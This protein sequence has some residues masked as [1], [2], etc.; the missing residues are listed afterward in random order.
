[1]KLKILYFS[2]LGLIGMFCVYSAVNAQS[3]VIS[4]GY[5]VQA[6]IPIP[7]A[8]AT[9]APITTH[10]L[11]LV[12]L[13]MPSSLTST[14][15]TFAVSST[16]NGTY[17][18]LYNSSGQVSYTVAASRYISINPSDFNGVY[19]FEVIMG[20]TE[21]AARTLTASMKGI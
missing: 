4:Q 20:S 17:V 19:Y 9:S 5:L 18:P 8:S 6:P 12:G 14:S 11:N 21:A 16:L 13:Q 1:M 3:Q 2:L 7:S 15:I 10:G